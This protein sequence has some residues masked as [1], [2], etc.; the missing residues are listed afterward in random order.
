MIDMCEYC[1]RRQDV[2]FGWKQPPLNC[3]VMGNVLVNDI[4][5]VVIHDY[6]TCEPE[7]IIK[8]EGFFDGDGCGT[9]YITIKYC[10]NCGRKLGANDEKDLD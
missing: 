5:E 4:V 3:K 10:P 6:Q 2:L 8:E 7:M 9:I 1:E